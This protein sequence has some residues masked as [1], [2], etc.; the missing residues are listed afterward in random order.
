MDGGQC[1]HH[2]AGHRHRL[3]LGGH[4]AQRFRLD[5]DGGGGGGSDGLLRLL[6]GLTV[7]HFEHTA[8]AELGQLRWG[9]DQGLLLLGPDRW[10]SC[11]EGIIMVKLGACD[12]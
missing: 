7:G 3:L 10:W 11:K 1:R 6:L 9:Q 5:D 12:E 2:G 4:R 8:L